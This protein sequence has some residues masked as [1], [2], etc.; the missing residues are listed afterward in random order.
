MNSFRITMLVL[1]ALG[2]M[3]AVASCDSV[4]I[5]GDGKYKA[6]MSNAL[7]NLK[8]QIEQD[9]T[10]T[11]QKVQ[12]LETLLTNYEAD[13][14]KKASHIHSKTAIASIKEAQADPANE[15]KN[16]TAAKAAIYMALDALKTEIKD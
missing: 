4:A 9:G 11:E 10:V 2:L 15:F 13:Y 12:K 8:N 5:T 14:G 3:L 1:V 7:Q 16:L 6:D